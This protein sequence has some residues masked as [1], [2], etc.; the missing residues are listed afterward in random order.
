MSTTH[1][2][3]ANPRLHPTREAAGD[4]TSSAAETAAL[5]ALE[6][7]AAG[8]AAGHVHNPSGAAV[9]FV[10]PIDRPYDGAG[11]EVVGITSPD[12]TRH[13]IAGA[14]AAG[15]STAI[16]AGASAPSAPGSVAVTG[17]RPDVLEVGVL[18][19]Q[20]VADGV[21]HDA[22]VLATTAHTGDGFDVI[23]ITG[24]WD[25]LPSSSVRYDWI[26]IDADPGAWWVQVDLTYPDV[27]MRELAPLRVELEPR[28]TWTIT[29]PLATG[30][31]ASFE[32]GG[33]LDAFNNQAARGWAR[34]GSLSLLAPETVY[35][36]PA[37]LPVRLLPEGESVR[38]I[39]APFRLARRTFR[40][41]GAL[42][43]AVVSC[44]TILVEHG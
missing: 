27:E 35:A 30:E 34:V 20:V 33:R 19:P 40:P 25:A 5:A 13:F 26:R 7:A 44:Y 11:G 37:F 1:F 38:A 15:G 24:A 32:V 21:A 39:A 3:L 10:Q 8:L 42:V 28:P 4:A 17:W 12:G 16:T 18:A 14:L 29:R 36:A 22:A 43:S 23:T 31:V 6:L 2:G 9:T 41:G